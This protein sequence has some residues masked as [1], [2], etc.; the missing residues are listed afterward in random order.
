[1]ED[2][3]SFVND[4]TAFSQEHYDLNWTMARAKVNHDLWLL[5]EVGHANSEFREIVPCQFLGC[6]HDVPYSSLVAINDQILISNTD[7]YVKNSV[8]TF[9]YKTGRP[10]KTLPTIIYKGIQKVHA[11]GANNSPVFRSFNGFFEAAIYAGTRE[12]NMNYAEAKRKVTHDLFYLESLGNGTMKFNDQFECN[13]IDCVHMNHLFQPE[14]AGA[15]IKTPTTK[16]YANNLALVELF[17]AKPARAS[18][19]PE[20]WRGIA[21]AA[22]HGEELEG[23]LLR[24]NDVQLTDYIASWWIQTMFDDIVKTRRTVSFELARLVH[25]GV[26]IKRQQFEIGDLRALQLFESLDLN[27]ESCRAELCRQYLRQ[28]PC[29]VTTEYQDLMADFDKT[30]LEG[31]SIVERFARVSAGYFGRVTDANIIRAVNHLLRERAFKVQDIVVCHDDHQRFR[32]RVARSC[33]EREGISFQL[34]YKA[35]GVEIAK[36]CSTFYI[37][38]HKGAFNSPVTEIIKGLAEYKA[39]GWLRV[40]HALTPTEHFSI[41]HTCCFGQTIE[42]NTTITKFEAVNHYVKQNAVL[43]TFLESAVLDIYG[44]DLMNG[45][46]ELINA[47]LANETKVETEPNQQIE[48]LK[49][50]KAV[51]SK[52]Q[53][54]EIDNFIMAQATASFLIKTFELE[55]EGIDDMLIKFGQLDYSLLQQID[56]LLTLAC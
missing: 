49:L 40:Y 34:A 26:E 10:L 3:V 39:A 51:I 47:L 14:V 17:D 11:A 33:V 6:K 4:A 21:I 12:F 8:L 43:M 50:L 16:W 52:F 28:Q 35:A 7:Y 20:I 15:S 18:F 13:V 38:N 54:F 53:R 37:M 31:G 32:V 46:S 1:M 25:I 44:V 42:L 56:D 55:T 27:L 22:K 36:I 24:P 19:S 48:H 45:C 2:Y 30:K 5:N 29:E 41:Y 23:L 9:I